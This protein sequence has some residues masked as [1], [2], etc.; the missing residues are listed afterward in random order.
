MP[1][2]TSAPRDG[3]CAV[4]VGEYTLLITNILLRQAYIAKKQI[5]IHLLTGLTALAKQQ[6]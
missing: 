6:W 1:R 3:C 4:T 2:A 5:Q